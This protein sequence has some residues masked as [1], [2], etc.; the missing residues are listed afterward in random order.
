[1]KLV[2]K[3]NKGV[4]DVNADFA[5]ILLAKKNEWVKLTDYEKEQEVPKAAEA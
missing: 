3:L 1:M 2:S 5:K 4:V